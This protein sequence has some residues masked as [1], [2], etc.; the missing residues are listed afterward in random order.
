MPGWKDFRNLQRHL[1]IINMI[2]MTANS[3]SNDNL[4]TLYQDKQGILSIPILGG[5]LQQFESAGRDLYA[6][7]A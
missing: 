7:A 3:L 2:P 5:G 6:L 4:P 1:R